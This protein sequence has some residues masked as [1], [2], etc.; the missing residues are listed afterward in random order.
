MAVEL[1]ASACGVS[2]YSAVRRQDL[3]AVDYGL[4]ENIFIM[5]NPY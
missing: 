5:H 3:I 4:Q 1:G 2:E